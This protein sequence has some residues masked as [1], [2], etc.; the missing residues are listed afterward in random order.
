MSET[1]EITIISIDYADPNNSTDVVHLVEL[2]D[3]RTISIWSGKP[4]YFI[5]DDCT[6]YRPRRGAR[7]VGS[8]KEEDR[9]VYHFEI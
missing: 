3:G 2:S 1:P 4:A 6:P 8:T 7:L 5:Y 9:T